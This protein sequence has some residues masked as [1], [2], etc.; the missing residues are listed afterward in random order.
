MT[1]FIPSIQLHSTLKLSEDIVARRI[2]DE[3]III[4]ITAGIGNLEDELYTLNET[5][6]AIWEKM[7]GK[8][9]LKQI[10]DLL[11]E[12]FSAPIEKIETDVLGLV[13]ELIKRRMLVTVD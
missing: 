6:I 1:E 3:L 11:H 13:T 10:A 12:E 4:P 5:A 7:D 2:E 8:R 9:S